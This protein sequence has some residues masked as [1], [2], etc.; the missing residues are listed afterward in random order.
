MLRPRMAAVTFHNP[1]K[2]HCYSLIS[3]LPFIHAFNQQAC[4]NFS[5]VQSL[6]WYDMSM[7][8]TFYDATP[9]YPYEIRKMASAIKSRWRIDVSACTHRVDL[10]SCICFISAVRCS[11]A[12][13]MLQIARRGGL[14]L[15]PF[16][17]GLLPFLHWMTSIPTAGSVNR[18]TRP[19]KC[20]T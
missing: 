15:S 20:S 12:F 2:A 6:L 3:L 10:F 14:F 1:A 11:L 19:N 17:V 18:V 16:I 5:F 9:R 13:Y 7:F 4:C 8:A